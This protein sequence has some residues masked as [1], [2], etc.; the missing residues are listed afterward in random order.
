MLSDNGNS[1]E[2]M[3]TLR[4]KNNAAAAAEPAKIQLALL[5]HFLLCS[6]VPD[7][8]E[9]RT[10]TSVRGLRTFEDDKHRKAILPAVRG[11]YGMS[12]R[13]GGCD[14][15]ANKNDLLYMCWR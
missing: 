13:I 2:F 6:G 3:W 10:A 1:F 9:E 5:T 14:S 11:V 12:V 7:S 15:A 8:R 4:S